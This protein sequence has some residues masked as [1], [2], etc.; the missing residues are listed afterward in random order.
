LVAP[1]KKPV[2]K[3]VDYAAIA[4]KKIRKPGEGHKRILIYARNKKGKT[5]TGSTAPKTLVLDPEKGTG[6]LPDTADVWPIDKWDD[7]SEAFK[8]LRFSDHD[9]E[10]VNVDGLTRINNMALRYVM[11]QQE[12]R[13]MD[14]IPGQVQQ[15]DYGKSGELL[16][17]MLFN[18]HTLPMGVVYTAQE[19][20]EIPGEFDSEDEDSE[21]ADA[22]FVPDLP[23][24]VRSSVNAIVDCIGRLYT[25]KID[26]PKTPD[27]QIVQRRLHIGTSEAF[28]TG[29]R[30]KH[31]LPDMIKNPTI[32][33][34][35]RLMN[36][37]TL[38]PTARK[39]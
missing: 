19:R 9:Y 24:G 23:K 4:A 30:S 21:Q 36:T 33:K 14:R 7:M 6:A 11:N 5:F 3:K 15:R 13:D 35:V 8:F 28:D 16:K 39:A 12:E 38:T 34:L 2:A 29:I 18:F 22:R 32:P 37:G 25:V 10:W 1:V 26:D 20:Q 31:K 27:L 17:G